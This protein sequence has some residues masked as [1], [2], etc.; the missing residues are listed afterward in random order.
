[1]R[2]I[3]GRPNAFI[4]KFLSVPIHQTLTFFISEND[5]AKVSYAKCRLHKDKTKFLILQTK[6]RIGALAQL[7]V[8]YFSLNSGKNC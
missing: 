5:R 6:K 8:H 4:A 1:M 3:D 2:S 7:W